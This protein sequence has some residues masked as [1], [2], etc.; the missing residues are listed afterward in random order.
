MDSREQDLLFVPASISYEKIVESR[1]YVRELSGAQKET[2]SASGL[3]KSV[4]L[5]KQ[6]YGRVYVTI[7]EPVSLNEY[8]DRLGLSRRLLEA[9]ERRHLIKALA[10]HIVYGI[11]SATVVTSTSL[12]ATALLGLR[13]KGVS[14][15]DLVQ[16][17]R[18]LL[19]QVQSQKEIRYRIAPGLEEELDERV[20][21]SIQLF[22]ADGLIEEEDT[23]SEVFY[24]LREKA[25][26]VL[27]YYKNSTIH[28]FVSDSI[29]A[30]VFLALERQSPTVDV[31][32]LRREV[33]RLSGLFKI[34]F[35]FPTDK[36][37]DE[38]FNESIQRMVERGWLFASEGNLTK[39][40]D[41]GL[42]KDLHFMVV[43]LLPFVEAYLAV[44]QKLVDFEG[45]SETQKAM[46]GILMQ[47]LK[48]SYFAETLLAYETQNEATLKNAFLAFGELGL[49]KSAKAKPHWCPKK[50][51][52]WTSLPPYCKNATPQHVRRFNPSA[53][54]AFV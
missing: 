38:L 25:Y 24:R 18:A 44:G 54:T 15:Q 3:M 27:D 39:T 50:E 4:G 12:V 46:L 29:V 19:V 42:A 43:L 36:P 16:K 35:I 2:E 40:Q 34:E 26:L 31:S 7:D 32:D 51:R 13:R 45:K 21:Q 41:A 6:K 23:D 14:H 30:T 47:S 11:N 5:L 22:V 17:A 52:S 37:F 9:E 48:S 1:S 20:H 28:L 8:L 10:Y 49:V 53:R 33:K